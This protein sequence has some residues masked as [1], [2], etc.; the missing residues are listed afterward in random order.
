MQVNIL[1]FIIVLTC[2]ACNVDTFLRNG[3]YTNN[4][5]YVILIERDSIIFF[6]PTREVF[7]LNNIN[8]NSLNFDCIKS[9]NDYLL[10]F[11]VYAI[12]NT[13]FELQ[14]KDECVLKSKFDYHF[15]LFSD[16]STFDWDSIVIKYLP[17]HNADITV[18]REEANRLANL[19]NSL[20]LQSEIQLVFS[21]KIDHSLQSLSSLP[22]S[23]WQ[24]YKNGLMIK[25]KRINSMPSYLRLLREY[26]YKNFDYPIE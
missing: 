19:T 23:R 10:S 16:T 11:K 4:S 24:L 7:S 17:E 13:C 20:S 2:F 14:T 3:I 9:T 5:G 18:N 12:S 15:N 1:S 26:A 25:E 6:T 22:Y 21:D 8:L